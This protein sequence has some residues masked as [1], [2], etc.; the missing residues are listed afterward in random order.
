MKKLNNKGFAITA[1]IYGLLV[2]FLIV[3]LSILSLLRFRI[4][5]ATN[6]SDNIEKNVFLKN[7]VIQISDSV[8]S[9]YTKYRAKYYFDTNNASDCYVYLPKYSTLIVS[10]GKVQIYSLSG[11]Q[12]NPYIG[13]CENSG[14]TDIK[15]KKYYVAE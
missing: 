12:D 1:T 7:E 14:I 11:T 2:L 10:D 4:K 6:I 8:T 3:L 5:N 13:N 9:Y 15:I